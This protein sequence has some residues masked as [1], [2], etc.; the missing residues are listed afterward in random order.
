SS[1]A[2]RPCPPRARTTSR[3]SSRRTPRREISGVVQ[4]AGYLGDRAR[5]RGVDRR[6]PRDVVDREPLG[7][8]ERD[9]QDELARARR[10]DDAPEHL[11]ARGVTEQLDEAVADAMHLRARVAR[12]LERRARVTDP[13]LLEPCARTAHRRDL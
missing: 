12:E 11:T 8:R 1:R 9:G 7:D 4:H 5:E 13:A 2:P 6:G 10:D 3:S